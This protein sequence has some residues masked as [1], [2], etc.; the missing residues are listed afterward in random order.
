MAATAIVTPVASFE[1]HPTR[2]KHWTFEVDGSPVARLVLDI[3]EE[4]GLR[5]DY[6]LKQNSY[7]LGVDIELHDAVERLRFEHPEVRTV[8]FTARSG[9][10]FC[11]GANIYMLGTSTHHF[12]VNFC[13]YTNETRCG[14]EEASRESGLRSIAA[15]NGVAAGGGYELA[16]ACDTIALIDD[17]NSAVSLPE[18]P[19]LGV[20]PG[21]G[22]LTRLVDKRKVRRDLADVFCT[23]AEGFRARDALKMGLIDHSFP[24]STWDAN[25]GALAAQLAQAS[26]ARATAGI[27]LPPL[28]VTVEADG[29]RTYG[30]VTMSVAANG[31]TAEIVVRAPSSA[32]PTTTDALR[33]AGASTWALAAFRELDD[34]LVHLR[35]NFPQV[36]L[37]TLRAEGDRE[38]VLAH[39]AALAALAGDW[40]A[41]EIRF[42]QG[43]TL[44]RLDNM[45][46]SMFAVVEPGNAFAGVLVEAM[47]TADRIYFRADDD[48]QNAIVVG[49][50]SDGRFPMAHGLSRLANR[51]T[52][53]PGRPAEIL[54]QTGQALGVD[55]VSDLGL[56]TL[57]PDDIDWDDELRIA[58]EERI[59]LSPDALTGMEQNLRYVGP[60]TCETRIY[61]RLSAWQNWIFQRPNA[62]GEHGALTLYGQPEQPRYDW[63]RT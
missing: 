50:A 7:D 42:Y 45:A 27:V 43:R 38:A 15:C 39:D 20:L 23:R 41:D 44:R 12:K 53:L 32:P 59:S 5:S 13:K 10:V 21:T 25:V 49:A 30:F 8:I 22:G 58:I 18:V 33:A 16:L 31:R 60:E 9:K 36:G 52:A 1:T 57:A 55:E 11:S 35:F 37:I 4:N 63:G 34:A 62:V 6:P 17:R 47:L 14:L 56:C 40:L 3:A 26:P 28:T 24:R 48:A 2:Y 54:A 46:K 61:G 19:L 29:G 51:F